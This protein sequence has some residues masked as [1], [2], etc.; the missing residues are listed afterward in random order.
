MKEDYLEVEQQEKEVAEKKMERLEEI[1]QKTVRIRK[2]R[3]LKA[4]C[5]EDLSVDE[6]RMILMEYERLKNRE[7]VLNGI[8]FI[9][10][11]EDL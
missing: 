11:E 6:V 3:I 8:E 5:K 1:R 9:P 4:I 2:D 10:L 7:D